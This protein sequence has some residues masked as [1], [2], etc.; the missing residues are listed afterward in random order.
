MKQFIFSKKNRALERVTIVANY[1]TFQSSKW[2][3][4]ALVRLTT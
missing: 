4:L 1:D 2:T 3:L